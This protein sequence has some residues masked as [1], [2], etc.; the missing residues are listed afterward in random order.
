MYLLAAPRR[1]TN[2]GTIEGGRVN[3]ENSRDFYGRVLKAFADLR[4]GACSTADAPGPQPSAALALDGLAPECANYGLA[5]IFRSTVSGHARRLVLDK[6]YVIEAFRVFPLCGNSGRMLAETRFAR[7][8][9]IFARCG[10]SLPF[11]AAGAGVAA[12]SGCC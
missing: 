4:T 2:D 7:H 9:G 6:R 8:F 11:D 12:S 5:T 1:I 10:T 3:I